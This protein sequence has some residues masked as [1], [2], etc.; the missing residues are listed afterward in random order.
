[1]FSLGREH[2]IIGLMLLS[3]VAAFTSQS[4]IDFTDFLIVITA[5]VL[6]MKGR[7]LAGFFKGF[8]PAVL[9]WVWL[10]VIG[11]GLFINVGLLNSQTWINFIEF[12]WILTLL[13]FIY[14]ISTLRSSSLDSLKS[15]TK[16]MTLITCVLLLLNVISIF[17]YYYR[18]DIR[19]AGIYNAI[20]AFS[21]SIAPI[22]CLYMVMAI[23]GWRSHSAFQKI[24]ISMTA[25][26]AGYLVLISYT[27]GVWLGALFAVPAVMIFWNYKKAI[28][29]VIAAILLSG[30]LLYLNKNFYDRAFSKTQAETSS[31]EARLALWKANLLMVRDYPLIGV[32]HG[33]NK[34][35]LPKYFAEIGIAEG[36]VIISHAHNQ[37]LQVWAGTGTLGLICYLYFLFSIFRNAWLG[38][39]SALEKERALML[40]LMSAV[41]CFAIGA[42]TEAN[43]NI[44][45]NR[46]L[47][48]LLVGLSIGLS[49]RYIRTSMPN[50]G[51]SNANSN[52][53]NQR[54]A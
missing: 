37:Y 3:M 26:T 2:L 7:D 4:L 12:K 18:T 19:A 11:A 27:R 6:A 17:L 39:K 24:V 28:Q 1:M 22:F 41:L 51:S 45:K 40:G 23:V 38:Y 54:Q 49:N 48:L 14:L 32:G 21:H 34:N 25:L 42:L 35:H 50:A 16:L 52:A 15:T 47:F 5:L 46:F 13:S 29:F 36:S 53:S 8:R 31:N 10:V 44:S 20:M 9:W 30:S 33:Q 43:F